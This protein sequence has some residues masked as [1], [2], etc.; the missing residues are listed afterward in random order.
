MKI[1]RF[2][3]PNMREALKAV[4]L[5]QGP[6][7]VILS[8]RRV[9]DYIEIIAALDYDEALM[10]QALRRSEP[11]AVANDAADVGEHGFEIDEAD[12]TSS[13]VSTSEAV[14]ALVRKVAT[15]DLQARTHRFDDTHVTEIELHDQDAVADHS[16]QD[17][18]AQL[19][20][21][22]QTQMSR[23]GWQQHAKTSP[24]TAQVL[25]NLSRLGLTPDVAEQVIGLIADTDTDVAGGWQAPVAALTQMVPAN[26]AGLISEGG[27]AAIVGPTGV[28]KT[29]TIAKL[30]ARF[31]LRHG[32]RN[33]ALVSMDSYRVGARDQLRLFARILNT[34]VYEAQDQAS[35]RALLPT[36]S[37]Y[38]LVLIDT[39]GVSQ[40]DP[41]LVKMLDGLT[42]QPTPVSLYLALAATAD[43]ELMDEVVLCYRQASLDGLIVTKTDEAS[44]LGAPLSMAIRHQLPLTY[45]CDGQHVP[46]NLHA[47]I[48]RKLWLVQLALRLAS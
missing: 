39:A 45:I 25:R 10:Q 27:V 32:S 16:L 26:D 1:K 29:T 28:G 38:Q 35:L 12:S 42:N 7:A 9:G 19:R 40:R 5:E 24:G 20:A 46:D 34:S 48:D 15:S 44:R 47:A 43:E 31:A 33:V 13:P 17:E 21:L 36:L 37:D 2:L 18:L 30:A 3:A 11:Q 8:N 4:R 14:S 23:S 22:L 41:R 6:D